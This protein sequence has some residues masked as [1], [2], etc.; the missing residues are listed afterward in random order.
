MHLFCKTA[1][2]NQF[3]AAFGELATCVLLEYTFLDLMEYVVA[4]IG[5]SRLHPHFRVIE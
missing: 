5:L 4:I 1:S 3:I 2:G